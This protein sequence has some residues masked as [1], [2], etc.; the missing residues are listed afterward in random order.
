MYFNKDIIDYIDTNDNNKLA[1][2]NSEILEF[3]IPNL[4]NMNKSN[5]LKNYMAMQEVIHKGYFIGASNF[6]FP[7]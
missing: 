1:N 6:K 4:D 2:I 3:K 5:S 7:S